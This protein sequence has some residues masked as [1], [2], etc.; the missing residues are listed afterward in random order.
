MPDSNSDLS[1]RSDS[2]S[3]TESEWS[4]A[5][6]NFVTSNTQ[7]KPWYTAIII[8]FNKSLIIN[9]NI[10]TRIPNLEVWCNKMIQLDFWSRSRT[11]KSDTDSYCRLLG[12]RLHPK[13]SHS[14][15][16]RFHNPGSNAKFR[17][18]PTIKVPPFPPIKFAYKNLK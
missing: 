17:P 5:V 8:C 1:K 16:L 15:R 18:G 3:L 7:W 10:S 14:L 11:K 6:H 12:I 9:C 4:L 13:I 2:D